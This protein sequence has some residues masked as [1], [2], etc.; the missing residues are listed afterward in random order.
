MQ[1]KDCGFKMMEVVRV[2]PVFCESLDVK[3]LR[4]LLAHTWTQY[5]S[6]N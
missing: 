6:K 4:V 1:Y 2:R 3:V 5:A